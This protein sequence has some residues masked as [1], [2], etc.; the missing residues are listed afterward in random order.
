MG[1]GGPFITNK[2][3]VDIY[4]FRIKKRFV[5]SKCILQSG[6]CNDII[7]SGSYLVIQLHA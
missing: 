7:Y 4:E 5:D 2:L 3:C 6:I 1:I